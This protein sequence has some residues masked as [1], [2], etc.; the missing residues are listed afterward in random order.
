MAGLSRIA[1]TLSDYAVSV[2]KNNWSEKVSL[3][4]VFA[5]VRRWDKTRFDTTFPELEEKLSV[6][7]AQSRGEAL[8]P[9]GFEPEVTEAL[10]QISNEADVWV[11]AEKLLGELNE[12]LNKVIQDASDGVAA[13]TADADTNSDDAVDEAETATSVASLDLALLLN[14][15]L[16]TIAEGILGSE[17][18]KLARRLASD[19][20]FVSNKVLGSDSPEVK[21]ALSQ[22]L[23][24]S[25]SEISNHGKLSMAVHDIASVN[26]PDARRIATKIAL[27]LVDVGE[28]SAALDD[29]VTKEE[30]DRIDT[31]RLELREQLADKIGMTRQTIAAIEQNKY[32]PSLEA[33][34]R[35]AEVFGVDIGQVFQW[36]TGQPD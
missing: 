29:N 32:S 16:V 20:L 24:L 10:Q 31:V 23:S 26:H 9:E 11:L 25:S 7:L 15:E 27:A 14:A 1:E 19:A 18:P 6:A 36:K 8:K 22:S 34:F 4:H 17:S 28:Y 33:A 21:N 3:L 30:T 12:Q 35:I 2:A 5:A 13:K